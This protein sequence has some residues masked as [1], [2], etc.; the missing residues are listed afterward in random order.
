MENKQ[1]TKIIKIRLIYLIILLVLIF[2]IISLVNVKNY[3]QR[4]KVQEA[5]QNALSKSSSSILNLDYFETEL[6]K[7]IGKIN[8]N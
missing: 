1:G 4:E 5:A 8:I 2:G 6:N 3:T 7:K